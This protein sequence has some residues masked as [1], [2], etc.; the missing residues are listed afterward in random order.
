MPSTHLIF[1]GPP[2]CG[3]GTQ[4]QRLNQSTGLVQ[5]SSGHVLR[6]EMC[7]GSAIGRR[8]TEFVEKG[9]LVPDDVITGI[10]LTA[11][12]KLPP[13]VGFI[14]DGFPRTRPQAES[15]DAGLASRNMALS[16]VIDFEIQDTV[17]VARIAGRRV[18]EN[19]G[20]TYNVE[21]LPPRVEGVCDVCGAESVVQR[22]D[23]K[24]DVVQNR[25][26]TYRSQTEPLIDYYRERGVL[27]AIDATGE[28]DAVE[29]RVL[30][31]VRELSAA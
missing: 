5:L 19:C 31:A 27:V 7:E 8:A 16:G 1:L 4:A 2:G 18:C 25:L 12:D 3:K 22:K 20:A 9:E 24:P 17:V 23:D 13:E 10:M 29:Q 15:L 26:A 14:L 21:F 6:T 11:I 30:D 28:A